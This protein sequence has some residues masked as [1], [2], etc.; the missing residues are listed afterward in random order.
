MNKIILI[1]LFFVISSCSS[2]ARK[3]SKIFNLSFSK[4]LQTNWIS[5]NYALNLTGIASSDKYII[6]SND[7]AEL[8][9]LDKNTGS[10][11]WKVKDETSLVG[12]AYVKNDKIYY[13]TQDGLFVTRNL[14]T[15]DLISSKSLEMGAESFPVFHEHYL[16]YHLKN[17]TILAI[18]IDTNE[19]V[20]RYNYPVTGF[21]TLNKASAPIVWN[22]QIIAGLAN[23]NLVSLSLSDGKVLWSTN[24]DKGRRFVDIDADLVVS[25]DIL[26]VGMENDNVALVSLKSG[27]ILQ[28]LPYRAVAIYFDNT[29]YFIGTKEG[30]IVAL[31]DKYEVLAKNKVSKKSISQILKWKNNIVAISDEGV[32][33]ALSQDTL[34]V[35]DSFSLGTKASNVYS[36]VFSDSDLTVYSSRYRLYNF[37]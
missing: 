31:N 10:V 2:V 21:A 36:T 18:D 35:L 13:T 37:K 16:F 11:V 22:G 28:R 32:L 3:Q 12:T 4:N 15:G 6:L 17:Y 9:S 33:R 7:N 5:G 30:E 8:M 34:T 25:G 26:W 1:L 19:E 14:Q 24:I 23:G 27:Q 29:H 20:W